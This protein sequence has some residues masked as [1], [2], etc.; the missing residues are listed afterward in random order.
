M[1]AATTLAIEETA[2]PGLL[3]VRRPRF[4]DARGS[5]EV[6]HHA[7]D[8]A[9]AG[10]D[11]VFVQD[12]HSVSKRG[13]V[14]GLHHQWP[15]PQGKLVSVVHGAVFDVA[16]DMR[17]GSPTFGAY[18]THELVAGD[19]LQLWIPPGFAHGFYARVDDTDVIYKATR[20]YIA[21][22]QQRIRWNDPELGIPWPESDPIL[23]AQDRAA[24]ALATT[25]GLPALWP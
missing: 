7:R 14:R 22:H 23:S 20:P 2:L 25:P 3:L 16:V 11:A 6:I 24:T 9:A 13:V 8:Y 4:T 5:F 17:E 1:N 12:N 15:M 21:D 10:L 18:I 19:G